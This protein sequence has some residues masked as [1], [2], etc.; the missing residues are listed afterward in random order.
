MHMK[1]VPNRVLLELHVP[2]FELVKDYYEKLGFE[3]VQETKPTGKAGCLILKTEDNILCFWAGND[4][5]DRQSYFKRFPRGTKRGYRVEV[6]LM[7]ADVDSDY[8]KVEEFANVIG[9]LCL[10]PFGYY[11][12]ITSLYDV[13]GNIPC[14]KSVPLSIT[15]RIL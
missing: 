2:D 13:T 5:V 1:P 8:E 12:R 3:V 14:K 9:P 6:V 15:G 10:R 11:L 7:V 4:A